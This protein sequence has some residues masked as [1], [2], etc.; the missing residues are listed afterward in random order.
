MGDEFRTLWEPGVQPL[1]AYELVLDL[2]LVLRSDAECLATE[3]VVEV[4]GADGSHLHYDPLQLRYLQQAWEGDTLHLLRR[5]PL[6]A[7]NTKRVVC[8]LWDQRRQNVE[9]A[10]ARIRTL[11]IQPDHDLR[12]P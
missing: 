1:L 3:L 2:E 7:G 5:I 12:N 11:R 9:L 8:Y 10:H 4:Q 6:L